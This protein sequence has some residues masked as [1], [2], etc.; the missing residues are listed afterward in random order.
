MNTYQVEITETLSRLIEVQAINEDHAR[1][2]VENQY[3]DYEIVLDS[4]DNIDIQF[5]IIN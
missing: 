3:K 1:Q 5:D 2:I 4:N